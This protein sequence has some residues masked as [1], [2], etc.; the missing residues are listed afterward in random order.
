MVVVVRE[1]ATRTGRALRTRRS[2]EPQATRDAPP[3][4]AVDR[5][6]RVG[7]GKYGQGDRVDVDVERLYV[8]VVERVAR[9]V[10]ALVVGLARGTA[11][12]ACCAGDWRTSAPVNR[13]PAGMPFRMNA[14]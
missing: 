12:I 13:P 1:T 8:D 5:L 7:V 4:D 2:R 14:W 9:L 3:D 10:V 11:Q 6:R